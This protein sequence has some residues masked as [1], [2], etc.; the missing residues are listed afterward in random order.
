MPKIGIISGSGL[1]DIPDV[2]RLGEEAVKTPY[3]EP[4]GPYVIAGAGTVEVALLSRHGAGHYIAPHKVNYRA[5][6]WGM[7]SLGVERVLGINAV[8]GID[9][10]FAPGDLVIPD[11]VMDFTVGARQST[12]YEGK[13]VIHIDFTEPYCPELRAALIGAARQQGIAATAFGTYVCTNGPRLESRAEIAFFGRAGG[14]VV[15]MTVM[16]EAALARELELCYASLAIV[17]NPAAGVSGASRLTATE[18]VEM[19]ALRTE[20]IKKLLLAA[21][22]LIPAERKCPCKDALKEARL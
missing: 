3:G 8:G 11:Q 12:F 5:N 10:E 4:S 18:I 15:G 14:H 22:A 7:K 17:T 9:P 1:Y 13:E 19:M 2:V 21:F 16:P 20:S 6:I